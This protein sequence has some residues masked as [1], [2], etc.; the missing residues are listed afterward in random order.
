MKG[1]N[2]PNKAARSN[3]KNQE[4]KQEK[5]GTDNAGKLQAHIAIELSSLS[6]DVDVRL[7]RQAC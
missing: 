3:R 7:S 1:L 4:I 5:S 2:R 6:P